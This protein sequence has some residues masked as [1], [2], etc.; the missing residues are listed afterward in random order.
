MKSHRAHGILQANEFFHSPMGETFL[1]NKNKIKGFD[2]LQGTQQV[3]HRQT[4]QHNASCTYTRKTYQC[5]TH[6]CTYG[7]AHLLPNMLVASRILPE[8]PSI[9]L[10]QPHHEP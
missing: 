9:M 2:N 8:E 7:E 5:K 10:E 3:K 6:V 1:N 4:K